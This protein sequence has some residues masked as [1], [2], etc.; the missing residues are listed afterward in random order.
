V[1]TLGLIIMLV[2]HSA[3]VQD[4]DGAKLVLTK[5]KG[6]FPRLLVLLNR[7]GASLLKQM[8]ATWVEE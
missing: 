5:M 2:V 3:G 4:R 1:D 8:G 7:K 6:R